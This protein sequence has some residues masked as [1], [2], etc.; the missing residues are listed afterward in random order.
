MDVLRYYYAANER[1]LSVS[2]N[3][4]PEN[5]FRLSTRWRLEKERRGIVLGS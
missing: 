1:L 5:R 3:L 4:Y 2:V